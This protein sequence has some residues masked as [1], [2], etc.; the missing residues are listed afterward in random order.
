MG[1]LEPAFP[2]C[3]PTRGLLC[4]ALGE[5]SST[6]RLFHVVGPEVSHP[7]CK[8]SARGLRTGSLLPE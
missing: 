2:L 6:S 8:V 3:L 1:V 5:V 7:G 4:N